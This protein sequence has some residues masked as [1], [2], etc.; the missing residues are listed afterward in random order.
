[1]TEFRV[2]QCFDVLLYSLQIGSHMF[3]RPLPRVYFN[4]IDS[5]YFW[6]MTTSPTLGS[7][8]IVGKKLVFVIRTSMKYSTLI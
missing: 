8:A 2:P 5:H 4:V 1:M 3:R 7:G 6:K